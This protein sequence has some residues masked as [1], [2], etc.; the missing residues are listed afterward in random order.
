MTT[1]IDTVRIDVP[2]S[3]PVRPTAPVDPPRDTASES[4]SRERSFEVESPD[5]YLRTVV[6]QLAYF[7][8]EAQTYVVRTRSGGLVGVPLRDITS[9]RGVPRRGRIVEDGL[10]KMSRLR[11][12]TIG[13]SP[14]DSR[15]AVRRELDTLNRR[16]RTKPTGV[17]TNVTGSVRVPELPVPLARPPHGGARC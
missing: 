11:D 13:S 9:S 10:S 3:S 14:L 17:S 15:L 12:A 8:D 2:K 6:G 4:R 1:L 16:L 5:G 7:D